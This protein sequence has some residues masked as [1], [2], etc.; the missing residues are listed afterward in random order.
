MTARLLL[1][2]LLAGT[3]TPALAQA[4]AQPGDDAGAAASGG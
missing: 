1:T 3:A 2:I 4:T